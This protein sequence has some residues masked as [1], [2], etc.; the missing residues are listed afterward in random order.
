M[1][2]PRLAP[3]ASEEDL[4]E[5]HRRLVRERPSLGYAVDGVVYKLDDLALQVNNLLGAWRCES[6]CK[7]RRYVLT[8]PGVRDQ[9]RV[10]KRSR[11]FRA[12]D[13]F[14]G[15]FIR[16]LLGAR[17]TAPGLYRR[18]RLLHLVLCDEQSAR[19]MIL[20]RGTDQI[21]RKHNVA[22]YRDRHSRL[23]SL[24]QTPC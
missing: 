24:T 11:W 9:E 21:E 16:A 7:W 22:T 20:E 10:E 23:R 8:N 18:L 1:A 5:F 6:N 3:T 19:P 4:V 14:V 17:A 2:R 12:V 13:A 15:S